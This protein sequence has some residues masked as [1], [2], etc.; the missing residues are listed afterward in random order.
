MIFQQERVIQFLFFIELVLNALMLHF[1]LFFLIGEETD[2][3][4]INVR[5]VV[6]VLLNFSD[7]FFAEISKLG[8]EF[9]LKLFIYIVFGGQK[10]IEV[11]LG[12]GLAFR[13]V[14]LQKVTL[15]L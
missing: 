1:D 14:F 5:Q 4:F 9:V 3:L 2:L 8:I 15:T 13:K 12:S 6:L 7:L 11:R 10:L